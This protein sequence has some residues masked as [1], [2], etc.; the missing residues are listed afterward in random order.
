[1]TKSKLDLYNF[2]KKLENSLFIKEL[3]NTINRA[4][5]QYIEEDNFIFVKQ[6]NLA[7]NYSSIFSKKLDNLRGNKKSSIMDFTQNNPYYSLYLVNNFKNNKNIIS[8]FYINNNYE[9]ETDF[10]DYYNSSELLITISQKNIKYL[11]PC[12][13]LF[14]DILAIEC[15]D[16]YKYVPHSNEFYRMLYSMFIEKKEE[17][18]S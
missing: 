14:S 4:F 1:M 3:I 8:I 16:N 15:D 2:H 6:S 17:V 7:L 12:L 18:V 11:N 10:N 9:Q 5:T 13:K